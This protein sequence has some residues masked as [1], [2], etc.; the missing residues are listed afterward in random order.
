MRRAAFAVAL[1][2]LV[3][4]AAI[5]LNTGR[6]A[7]APTPAP[8]SVYAPGL[9]DLMTAYVQPHHIKLWFAGI[10][11]NW[12]LAAYEASE[13]DETFDDVVSYQGNWHDLPIGSLVQTLIRPQLKRVSAAI[14]AKDVALFKTAYGNL[15]DSCNRCHSSAQHDFI[16]IVTPA[17]NPYHDQNLSAARKP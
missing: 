10:S 17:A 1:M 16:D 15:N 6:A 9:G 5:A 2:A 8:P 3:V 12:K 4:S 14:E 7:P 13:L 11:G